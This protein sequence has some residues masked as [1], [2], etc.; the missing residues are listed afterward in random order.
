MFTFHY[1]PRL[2]ITGHVAEIFTFQVKGELSL[3]IFMMLI[4]R[5]FNKLTQRYVRPFL[6]IFYVDEGEMNKDCRRVA[7]GGVQAFERDLMT[8]IDHLLN[9]RVSCKFLQ[10]SKLLYN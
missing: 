3:S 4:L 1:T 9:P 2:T 7:K 10:V 8:S 5:Q 6:S